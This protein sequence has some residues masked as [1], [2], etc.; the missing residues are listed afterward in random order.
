MNHPIEI[1]GK[2]DLTMGLAVAAPT[3]PAEH[4][5]LVAL[6][7]ELQVEQFKHDEAYHR[8]IARLPVQDRLKHMAL[9]LAKYAGG[10]FDVDCDE[11]KLKRLT[12]DI[13]IISLSTLNILNAKVVNVFQAPV[14]ETAVTEEFSR[15]VVRI[16]GR[17]SAACEK[18]DHLEDYPFRKAIIESAY[19]MLAVS[20]NFALRRGWDVGELVRARLK[21]IKE[22]SIFF[23]LV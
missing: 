19:C 21:P 18:M 20:L 16:S 23:G 6:L 8:E 22:K 15:E 12:T 10:L 7:V 13:F 1:E 17:I 5:N 9:H 4:D 14:Q 3:V 11:Q 2:R